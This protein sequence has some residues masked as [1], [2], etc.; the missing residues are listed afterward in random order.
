MQPPVLSVARRGATDAP[1]TDHG[2]EQLL[3]EASASRLARRA[4]LTPRDVRRRRAQLSAI[5]LVLLLTLITVTA[6]LTLASAVQN[7]VYY[8]AGATVQ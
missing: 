5:G 4:H 3:R 8:P 1:R 2:W 7:E 6:W